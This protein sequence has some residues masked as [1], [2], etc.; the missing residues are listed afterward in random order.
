MPNAAPIESR[1]ITTAFSDTRIDRN[2]SRSRTNDSASTTPITSGSFLAIWS[3]R[4]M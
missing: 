4:S 1:F 2:A 3:A